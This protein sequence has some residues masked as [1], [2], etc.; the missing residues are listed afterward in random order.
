MAEGHT[1]GQIR[2]TLAGVF[3]GLFLAALDQTVIATALPAI[4]RDLGGQAWYAWATVIYLLGSTPAA[5][6]AGRLVEI[7]P[8]KAVLLGALFIFLLGSFLSGL[9]PTFGAF[10]AFRFVQGVGGGALFSLGFTTLAWFFPPRERSRWAGLIGALFGL[11]SAVGPVLGGYLTEHFSWRWAF[12][13]NVPLLILAIAF[14][15]LFFPAAPAPSRLPMD[16]KGTLLLILWVAPTLIA[17]S[18]WGPEKIAPPEVGYLALGVALLFLYRWIRVEQASA[19][20]LFDLA[21]VRLRTF[22]YAA[23]AGFFF[24]PVFL[25][26][27]TFFPLYLQAVLGY[28]PAQ[29]GVLLLAFTVGAVASTGAVGAWVSRHGR[30]KPL[31]LGSAVLLTAILAVAALF[32]PAKIA[33]PALLSL[34]VAGAALLGPFQ[35]LLSVIGQ[36]DA[37]IE[38]VGSVTSAIQF[39]RQMG[40]TM[41]LA[42]FNTLFLLGKVPTDNLLLG[43]RAVFGGSALLS[44]LLTGMIAAL[45]DIRL[46][47]QRVASPA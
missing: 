34:M 36:N 20:P 8:R 35:A 17:F 39:A 26:G 19:A 10:L 6:I 24:G 15:G 14:V 2:L 32:L 21:L 18:C 31:L 33:Q 5:P 30:F 46:R 7:L 45:P 4:L 9:A 38:R 29:S 43:L 3:L 28:S 37:P 22:R 40:S 44:L 11:A 47:S 27:V 13:V 16:W 12:W 25:G 42:L 23:L 41:G 1:S